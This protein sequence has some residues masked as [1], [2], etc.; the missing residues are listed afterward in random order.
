[1]D[2][3]PKSGSKESRRRV[4]ARSL[5]PEVWLRVLRWATFV[6]NALDVD[7]PNP[8]S[9]PPPL[10]QTNIQGAIRQSLRTKRALVRVC[11][12]WKELSTRFLYEAVYIGLTTT[13]LK[14]FA[15]VVVGEEG[16]I[17]KKALHWTKRLDFAIRDTSKKN[18][19]DDKIFLKFALNLHRFMPNLEILVARKKDPHTVFMQ[20]LFAN[21]SL[22][23][24][25]NKVTVFDSSHRLY[26]CSEANDRFVWAPAQRLQYEFESWE[27]SDSDDTNH[28]CIALHHY[29]SVRHL[30]IQ[31]DL[32]A[33]E[34]VSK[35]RDLTDPWRAPN[36]QYLAVSD[37]FP[38]RVNVENDD[39]ANL[40]FH[41]VY[42]GS[43]NDSSADI[44]LNFKDYLTRSPGLPSRITTFECGRTHD[45]DI[46][47]FLDIASEN[48]PNLQ[49]V[50]LT[51]PTWEA[52]KNALP[53]TTLPRTV[54][55]LGVR[56]FRDV[57]RRSLM[58]NVC[59]C[60]SRV[61]ETAASLRV[62]RIM[63]LQAS[64]N[65][66]EVNLPIALKMKN[67]LDDKKIRL[68]AYDGTLLL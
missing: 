66:R 24:F 20:R 37:W 63:G 29:H 55:R 23:S 49:N 9:Y 38:Y 15:Y 45:M 36:L 32:I 10:N 27:E 61:S 5:P 25:Q 59:D 28:W 52:L 30:H 34:Y 31:P 54:Q 22:G 21:I 2:A 4:S 56:S 6:P 7:A 39:D 67:R 51:V 60:L 48:C 68:E 40:P 16:S 43:L 1:M 8:F 18:V 58:R 64:R 26:D 50:I 41:F 65:L 13:V 11:R 14:I 3:N 46:P 19:Q 57:G 35:L 17:G 12:Q 42:W 33:P 44:N 53:S 47:G 62:V